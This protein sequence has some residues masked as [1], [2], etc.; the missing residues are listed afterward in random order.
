MD[1]CLSA[2]GCWSVSLRLSRMKFAEV[3][4]SL[5]QH[6]WFPK[7]YMINL[8]FP[9]FFPPDLTVYF[10]GLMNYISCWKKN[11]DF[12]IGMISTLELCSHKM[13]HTCENMHP[14]TVLKTKARGSLMVV[15]WGVSPSAAL[16][17]VPVC[18]CMT[19]T[20]HTGCHCSLWVDWCSQW[21]MLAWSS[22]VLHVCCSTACPQVTFPP[23]VREW[24]CFCVRKTKMTWLP[25]KNNR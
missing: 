7:L 25:L 18:A 1:R 4:I 5:Y 17:H 3:C 21:L 15:Q 6:S 11:S 16:H 13:W 10:K 14:S 12:N 8:F 9:L 22:V 19:D 23:C 2:V 24:V 20:S